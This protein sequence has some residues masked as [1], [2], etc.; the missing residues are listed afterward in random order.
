MT[1]PT[2]IPAPPPA[3]KRGDYIYRGPVTEEIAHS[4]RALFA[5]RIVD[6]ICKDTGAAQEESE[7][8]DN[9]RR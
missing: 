9:G 6:L 8:G 2:T 5:G 3:D 1:T 4:L 7:G